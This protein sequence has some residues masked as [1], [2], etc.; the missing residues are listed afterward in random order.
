MQEVITTPQN[1]LDSKVEKN[2]RPHYPHPERALQFASNDDIVL[3]KSE[4]PMMVLV[5]QVLLKG[6]MDSVI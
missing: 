6:R 3:E 5:L 2:M 4:T 1:Q